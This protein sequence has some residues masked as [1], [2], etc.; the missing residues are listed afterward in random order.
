[1]HELRPHCPIADLP[2]LMDAQRAEGYRVV[3]SFDG[4]RAVAVAGFR[5][6]TKLTLGRNLYVDDLVTL[7]DARGA[8]HARGLL[9]WMRAEAA[10]LGCAVIHLDSNTSRHPAHRLYLRSGYDITAFH[11][12]RSI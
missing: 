5:V 10:R 11:F 6:G 2:R 7:P 12:M 9:E 8:G 4:Y 3:A 1:M